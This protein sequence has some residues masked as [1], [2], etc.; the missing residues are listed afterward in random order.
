MWYTRG[1]VTNLNRRNAWH[2]DLLSLPTKVINRQPHIGIKREII[3][4]SSRCSPCDGANVF[5][6]VP[7]N[8][9]AYLTVVMHV[10]IHL[11]HLWAKNPPV[12]LLLDRSS[13]RS[14]IHISMLINFRLPL[15]KRSK[16]TKQRCLALAHM[17][18]QTT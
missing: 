8:F 15:V 5:I 11:T 16:K 18:E 12:N 10:I 1:S 6:R 14:P 13:Y 4:G 2:H 17:I 9:T 7:L 3:K